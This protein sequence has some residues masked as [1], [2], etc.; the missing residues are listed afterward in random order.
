[1]DMWNPYL[2][3]TGL[4]TRFDLTFEMDETIW[5]ELETVP[6]FFYLAKIWNFLTYANRHV[7]DR[8]LVIRMSK[9]ERRLPWLILRR[10]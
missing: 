5:G 7:S 9:L 6:E 2:S 4:H 1:M 8:H 3:I 10:I